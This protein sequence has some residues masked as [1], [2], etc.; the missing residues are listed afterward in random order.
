MTVSH[1]HDI[2]CVRKAA[3]VDFEGDEMTLG[4][5]T[6]TVTRTSSSAGA[7]KA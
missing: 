5:Q 3:A 4:T 1:D 6:L 2:L 7:H